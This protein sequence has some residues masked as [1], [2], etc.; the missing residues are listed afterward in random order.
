M[1]SQFSA[2][3]GIISFEYLEKLLR[4]IDVTKVELRSQS[5]ANMVG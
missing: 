5:L 1:K 3:T 4:S 2:L